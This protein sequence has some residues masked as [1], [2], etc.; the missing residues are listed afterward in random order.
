MENEYIKDTA[1]FI[2]KVVIKR[3]NGFYKLPNFNNYVR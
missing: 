3:R 1:T 2:Y